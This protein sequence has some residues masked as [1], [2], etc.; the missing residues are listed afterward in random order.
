MTTVR[1]KIVEIVGVVAANC[2][3][4]FDVPIRSSCV[5]LGVSL[6]PSLDKPRQLDQSLEPPPLHDFIRSISSK[7]RS[8]QKLS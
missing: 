8:A 6:K 2:A 4:R 1:G 7:R 5:A 3:S